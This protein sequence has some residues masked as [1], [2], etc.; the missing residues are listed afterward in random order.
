M[1]SFVLTGVG[2]SFL[3]LALSEGLL[4]LVLE[5]RLDLLLVDFFVVFSHF[6][7]LSRFWVVVSYFVLNWL[8]CCCFWICYF[9]PYAL[10]MFL[11]SSINLILF[12][13]I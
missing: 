13:N 5:Y 1:S 10:L 8:C 9:C 11:I 7:F 3:E 6:L 2:S 12:F 4:C